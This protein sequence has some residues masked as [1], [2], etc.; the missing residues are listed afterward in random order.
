MRKKDGGLDGAIE[1]IV[2]GV[3]DYADDLEPVVGSWS[4]KERWAVQLEGFAAN[5]L[6]DSVTAG[7]EL[8]HEGFVHDGNV[9]GALHFPVVKSSAGEERDVQSWKFIGA[10]GAKHGLGVGE[11]R[12][13][14]HLNF[15]GEAAEARKPGGGDADIFHAG[16][17]RDDFAHRFL[18]VEAAFPSGIGAFGESDIY[19]EDVVGIVAERSVQA[20]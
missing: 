12:I 10:D 16:N 17:F 2:A 20:R 19:G 1:A 3:A 15:C 18:G 14:L 11:L 7:N 8:L 9:G 13:A 6:A 4:E 5:G